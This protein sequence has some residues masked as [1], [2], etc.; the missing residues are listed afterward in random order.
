MAQG[1]RLVR[2]TFSTVNAHGGRALLVSGRRRGTSRVLAT[3][4]SYL[5]LRCLVRHHFDEAPLFHN[6]VTDII[7]FMVTAVNFSLFHCISHMF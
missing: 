3:V 1:G 2:V 5:H 6:V 4:S 7:L